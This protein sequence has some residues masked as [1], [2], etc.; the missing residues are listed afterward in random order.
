MKH[1]DFRVTEGVFVMSKIIYGERI[2]T[3]AKLVVACDG[4]IFDS[5]RSKMLLTQRADNRQWC[6]PGGRME[7]GE[8]ASECCAR[9]VLEETALV[10]TVGRLV[11]VYSTPNHITEYTD[12]NRKQGVDIIF[13][14]Q[15]IGGDVQITEETTDVGY[16]SIEE[17][18]SLDIVELM[19]E[20]IADA[21]LSRNA[22]FIR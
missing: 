8:S 12:G 16:F 13:E 1:T 15:I 19:K 21:F 3:T 18:G 22:A 9:E 11:G 20:R 14:T 2:G 10:V 7:P 5:T 17:M 6:L 4:V